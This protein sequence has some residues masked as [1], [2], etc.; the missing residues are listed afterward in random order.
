MSKKFIMFLT[1]FSLLLVII[2]PVRGIGFTTDH[3]SSQLIS[4]MGHGAGE[5]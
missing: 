3:N 5:G 1:S 4:T 2:L